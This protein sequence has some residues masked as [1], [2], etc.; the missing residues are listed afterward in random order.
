MLSHEE[1]VAIAE[2]LLTK[3]YGGV[4]TL[5]DVEQL[6]G[7]GTSAVLRARVANSPFLQQRSVV[8]KY[9]PST[10]DVFDD[11]ALVREIVSYQFTTSL[12]EDVRPGPVILA[13]DIDKRIIVISDSGNGDTFAELLD[14]RTGDQRMQILRNLGQS[15]GS[16]HAATADREEDFNILLN[17]ML[18]KYPATAE[19]Q[20]N[21][22]RL[23]PAAIEVGKK[24]LI[25]AGVTV[26]EVVEEFARVARRRLTSG[27]HRAFTPFDLSPDNI[28][29]A[30]RTHFLDYE[31]A[32]FRDATFDVACVIAGFPQFVFSRPISDDEADELIDSWVQEVRGI[33]PNVNNEERL[34]ARIVTALIGW[35]LSSV[36]FM[37]LGSI[38]G[39]LNLLHVSE[40]GN[41]EI[42]TADLN[43]LL[44]P[45]SAE[46]DE[47]VQQD[48]HETFGALQRFAARG[49]DSRFPE[50]ARFADDVVRLFIKTD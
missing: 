31:V 28:I 4:Q 43:E 44:L 49:L 37:K 12:S 17:R 19:M 32:G 35:A 38:S 7:S 34:Q 33:W 13:Y 9:V 50:V 46:D 24:I 40:D 1:I 8:L 14:Q 29:V 42:D 23:L 30:D 11:S 45:R 26:P 36:A 48:L 27:R 47:L 22:D 10:G 39:M 41:T 16:L 25:D 6:N 21:R 15:L 5:S 18:A 2:D 3:R 20:K